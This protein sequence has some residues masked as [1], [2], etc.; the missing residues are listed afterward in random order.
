MIMKKHLFLLTLVTLMC[1]SCED[2][3]KYTKYDHPRWTVEEGNYTTSMSCVIDLPKS[4]Q[5][6]KSGD[7]EL[8][9]FANGQCRG[10]ATLIN[11][12]FFID[13]VG[14]YDEVSMLEFRYYS[15]KTCY[16]YISNKIQFKP[17]ETIGS[18]DKPYVP[19]L[20]NM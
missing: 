4:L 18:I 6:Y 8:A 5:T 2:E 12:L 13:P 15:S 11:N 14:S 16:M 3:E 20:T 9:V 19:T 7:D 17:D 1:F 10:T